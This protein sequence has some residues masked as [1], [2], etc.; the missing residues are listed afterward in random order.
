MVGDAGEGAQQ[1]DFPEILLAFLAPVVLYIVTVRSGF[2][3]PGGDLGPVR[4]SYTD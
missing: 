1:S 3:Q 4:D 2:G